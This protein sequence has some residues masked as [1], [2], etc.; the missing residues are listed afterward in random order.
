MAEASRRS[1]GTS[2]TRADSVLN[3]FPNVAEVSGR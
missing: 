3:R 1:T 2:A